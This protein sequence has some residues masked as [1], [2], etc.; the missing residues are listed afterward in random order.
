M[1]FGLIASA[2][3]SGSQVQILP[4]RPSLSAKSNR[5]R[6]RVRDSLVAQNRT[7][8]DVA[9]SQPGTCNADGQHGSTVSFA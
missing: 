7:S 2:P 6:H 4:L 1:I 3:R 9:Q 5:L 8:L